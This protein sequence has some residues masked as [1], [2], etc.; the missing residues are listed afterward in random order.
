MIK[1]EIE[2]KF[3][4]ITLPF[5]LENGV[6]IKQGYLS[7]DPVIRVRD[8][9]GKYFLTV[10]NWN[11]KSYGE[12]YE[13][14]LNEDQFHRLWHK[15]DMGRIMK[16]RHSVTIDKAVVEIDVFCAPFDGLIILEVEFDNHEV[17]Q[18]FTPPDWFGKEV[19]GDQRFNNNY[20]A[21]H[22]KHDI[23]KML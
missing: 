1:M 10:K 12:E 20:L 14:P 11:E 6:A 9:G 5:A 17:A 3:L 18:S 22:G 19:T 23:S 8:I 2:R 21:K 7:D 16:T 15:V 13:T 4:P